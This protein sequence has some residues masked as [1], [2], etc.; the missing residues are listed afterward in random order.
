MP[1]ARARFEAFIA[2]GWEHSYLDLGLAYS[3]RDTGD[4]DGA[5]AAAERLLASR[6][7]DD[8]SP[9]AGPGDLTGSRDW[10]AFFLWRSGRIVEAN[11]KL[12]PRTMHA[13]EQ[14]PLAC[15]SGATPSVLFSILAPGAHIPPHNGMVNTPLEF[16]RDADL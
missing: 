16:R 2:G 6:V 9:S 15:S 14:V 10:T 4:L 11:A 7:A 8:G 1:R 3:R 13:L 5:V 12:C